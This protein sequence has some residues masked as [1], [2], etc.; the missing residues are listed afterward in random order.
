FGG[1]YNVVHHTTFINELIKN[2]RLKFT[3]PIKHDVTFHD[4]CYL[5]RHNGEYD[6]PRDV[7]GASGAAITEM[8]RSRKNSLCCGAGGGQFWKEEE[9]GTG[10]VNLTRYIEAKSTGTATLAVGCPFC[11]R[12]FTDASQD[13]LGLGGPVVK[14]IVEIAAESMGLNS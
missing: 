11:I 3:T 7:L 6:S 5:G 9:H 8:P 2:G 10:R 14:D 1:N 12:M 4:P 13:E